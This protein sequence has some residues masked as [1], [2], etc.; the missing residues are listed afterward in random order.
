MAIGVAT[1]Q[2][3]SV[4]AYSLVGLIGLS[5]NDQGS[6]PDPT[7]SGATTST[8]GGLATASPALQTDRGG[9][10]GNNTETNGGATGGL[11][12]GSSYASRTHGDGGGDDA[13]DNNR[14]G[15]GS[16][17]ASGSALT[18]KDQGDGGSSDTRGGGGN[19]TVTGSKKVVGA[20]GGHNQ[21]SG[22]VTGAN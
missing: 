21:L 20:G 1:G 3:V 17:L 14:I 16:A 22:T 10:T 18:S 13:G 7:D 2:L 6:E 12:P 19:S 4:A 9:G 8:A 15:K 5:I 11:A